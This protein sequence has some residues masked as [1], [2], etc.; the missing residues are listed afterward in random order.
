[1]KMHNPPHPGQLVKTW[2]VE[3]EDGNKIDSV[4]GAAT[5]IG[6]TRNTLN[7]VIN[8]SA[9]ISPEM[10]LKL[11]AVGAGSAEMWLGMQNA[12]TLWQLRQSAA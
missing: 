4:E 11:E 6:V 10:A 5:R 3:D 12:Y 9:S 7:R 1:M 2:L 8:G